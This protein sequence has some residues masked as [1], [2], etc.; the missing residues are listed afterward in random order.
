MFQ[1]PSIQSH[2]FQP[3]I[4]SKTN[5]WKVFLIIFNIF[6]FLLIANHF[7]ELSSEGDWKY[8]ANLEFM[9]TQRGRNML[10]YDG[11][12]YVTNQNSTKNI[13]WRCSHYVKFSCRAS[14]VT[15]RDLTMIRHAGTAHSHQP[16]KKDMKWNEP[17][18]LFMNFDLIFRFYSI[19]QTEI[20][21]CHFNK[22][23]TYFY[24]FEC[25]F[26][27]WI[28]YIYCFKYFSNLQKQR[29]KSSLI[30]HKLSLFSFSRFK[31]WLYYLLRTEFFARI[32][33]E[34]TVRIPYTGKRL[35]NQFA[36]VGTIAFSIFGMSKQ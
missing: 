26:I 10:C 33:I 11:Y 31:C 19:L 3:F 8:V 5:H 17:T 24:Y 32:P 18:Y 25:D 35:Q 29:S 1:F 22:I 12:R 20:K 23:K 34:I 36:A 13:F 15:S 9:K 6:L 21:L 16:D 28:F 30:I 4:A 7:T 14:V 2:F 27:E